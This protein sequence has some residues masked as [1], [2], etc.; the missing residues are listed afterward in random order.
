MIAGVLVLSLSSSW[1]MPRAYRHSVLSVQVHMHIGTR[2]VRLQGISVA[3]V[4]GFVGVSARII[5]CPLAILL[6]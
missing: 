6:L 5:V 2:L 3:T 1:F 4:I